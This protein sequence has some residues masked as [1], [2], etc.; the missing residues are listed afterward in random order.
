MGGSHSGGDGGDG[1]E[2]L[3]LRASTGGYWAIGSLAMVGAVVLEIWE[4]NSFAH[5]GVG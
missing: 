5:V 4:M 3:S 2:V 1:C